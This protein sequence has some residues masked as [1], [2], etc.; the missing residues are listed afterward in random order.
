MVLC[1]IMWN[2]WIIPCVQQGCAAAPAPPT[3]LSL[4][5]TTIDNSNGYACLHAL[6]LCIWHMQRFLCIRPIRTY[7]SSLTFAAGKSQQFV[8]SHPNL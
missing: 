1:G 4:Q 3:M 7:E 5:P 8:A 2:K 6:L